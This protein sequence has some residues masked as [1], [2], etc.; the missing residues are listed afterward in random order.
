[1]DRVVPIVFLSC[2]LAIASG[3][4]AEPPPA[5]VWLVAPADREPPPHAPTYFE[6]HS[7]RVDRNLLRFQ[8]G[9]SLEIMRERDTLQLYGATPGTARS[10]GLGVASFS[11][12]VV[13]SA[14]TPLPL[15]FAFDRAF[16]VGPA[17]FD[18]GG[19]GAGFGGRLR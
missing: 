11:A 6:A 4:E 9:Y 14:H 10:T 1:V 7:A 15:R 2:A 3:A 16:H 5:P 13:S 8:H 17:I 12:A 18:G 19:L